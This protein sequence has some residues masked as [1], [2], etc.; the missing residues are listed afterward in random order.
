ML[1]ACLLFT[2]CT[3]F[4]S[5]VHFVV[6]PSPPPPRNTALARELELELASSDEILSALTGS[7]TLSLSY[8]RLPSI[9]SVSLVHPRPSAHIAQSLPRICDTHT[10]FEFPPP[11]SS[12]YFRLSRSLSLS[13]SYYRPS[14]RARSF[15][16]HG[17]TYP[18]ACIE[19]TM[20]IS[21][22]TY[23]NNLSTG[24]LGFA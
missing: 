20:H 6:M 13:L 19:C 2:G 10:V 11:P 7:P 3:F 23:A 5:P 15:A 9:K 17:E 8:P 18:L 1:L 12:P 4:E 22:H 24:P 21:L 14:P 16:V